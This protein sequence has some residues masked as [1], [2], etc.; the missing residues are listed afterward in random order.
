MTLIQIVTCS[1]LSRH[2][3]T[4]GHDAWPSSFGTLQP[5]IQRAAH[6]GEHTQQSTV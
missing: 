2:P 4:V 6:T 1:V 5:H 3:K